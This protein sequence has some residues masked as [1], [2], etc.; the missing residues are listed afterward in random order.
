MRLCWHVKIEN[1]GFDRVK[2]LKQ[3]VQRSLNLT[4]S[5]LMLPVLLA[6]GTVIAPS[7]SFPR[8]RARVSARSFLLLYANG[9]A[10]G[11]HIILDLKFAFPSNLPSMTAVPIPRNRDIYS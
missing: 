2:G 11:F 1:G 10:S 4:G 6:Q 8:S 5:D 7:P 9:T 3:H